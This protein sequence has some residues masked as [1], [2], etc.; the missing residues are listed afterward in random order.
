MQPFPVLEGFF[1]L[2][3]V[4]SA[5]LF[6]ITC[7]KFMRHKENKCCV[8]Q[9]VPDPWEIQMPLLNRANFQTT[10]VFTIAITYRIEYSMILYWERPGHR[11]NIW[12][13]Q[14]TVFSWMNSCGRVAL[15]CRKKLRNVW[16][17]RR[18]WLPSRPQR[19]KTSFFYWEM[20]QRFIVLR[21]HT[22]S[23]FQ[24][25]TL[26]IE[27]NVSPYVVGKWVPIIQGR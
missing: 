23:K 26:L 17:E 4:P 22:R 25:Q 2:V 19:P 15:S 20:T 18:Y 13:T 6:V 10:T 12:F 11:I 16:S 27:N 5:K 3:Y 24:W 14:A 1:T 7:K 8:M 21:K 9:L